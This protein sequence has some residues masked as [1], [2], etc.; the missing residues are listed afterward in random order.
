M[1]FV[2]SFLWNP[3]LS[4]RQCSRWPRTCPTASHLYPLDHLAKLLDIL[5]KQRLYY[6]LTPSSRSVHSNCRALAGLELGQ[7]HMFDP[8]LR[9]KRL[10]VVGVS[11]EKGF[12][13]VIELSAE[14]LSTVKFIP[15]YFEEIWAS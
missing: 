4:L 11:W 1:M 9:S 3:H 12:N 6:K 15:A 10:N 7:L 13:Q 5:H 8:R 14:I 2:L